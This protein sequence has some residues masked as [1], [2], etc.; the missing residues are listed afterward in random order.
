MNRFDTHS[1]LPAARDAAPAIQELSDGETAQVGGGW[2][3][4]VAIAVACALLLEHD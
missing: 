3:I 1:S 2:L 4:I